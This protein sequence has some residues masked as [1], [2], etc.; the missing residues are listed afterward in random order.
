MKKTLLLLSAVMAMAFIS[1]E[2]NP[3]VNYLETDKVHESLPNGVDVEFLNGDNRW[4]GLSLQL[5]T[6]I[7]M[8]ITNNGNG[9]VF[10]GNR[11]MMK[12]TFGN[13]LVYLWNVDSDTLCH[14]KIKLDD[15]LNPNDLVSSFGE[16]SVIMTYFGLKPDSIVCEIPPKESREV[17]FC[18]TDSLGT[19]GFLERRDS[20]N[21]D[22]NHPYLF[23]M[24]IRESDG[25][26]MHHEL[27]MKAK[28][29]K[30]RF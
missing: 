21:P 10:I 15:V 4:S 5:A 8:K 17:E 25:K 30:K 26:K 22:N 16:D 28:E 29:K 27:G 7:K 13:H 1:C 3:I 14:K 24:D 12:K 23:Y 6:V 11:S 9:K 19:K 2:S 20:M 18:F